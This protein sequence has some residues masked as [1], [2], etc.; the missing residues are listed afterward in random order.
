VFDACQSGAVT[1]FKGGKRAEPFYLKSQRQI[2]G[3]V[4]IA[5][6]SSNELAQESETLKGSIFSHHWF[7]G[8]RGSAD[9]SGDGEVTVS[10]AYQYAYRKTIETTALSGG[11]VQHPQYRF[12]I[13][14]HGDIALTSLG[15]GSAG[16]VFDK[17]FQGKF[18]VLSDT[19]SD[20]YADFARK[21]GQET[22]IA[23]PPGTYTVVNVTDKET[24][25][26]DFNLDQSTVYRIQQESLLPNPV[27]MNRVKGANLAASKSL[28]MTTGPLSTYSWGLGAGAVIA[29][30]P[31]L[32][33]ERAI[34]KVGWANSLY[35]SDNT[36]LFFNADWIAFGRNFSGDIGFDYTWPGAFFHPFAGIGVGVAN[37]DKGASAM[38][39][40]LGPSATV[41]LGFN[42]EI[43]GRTGLR[44]QV[45]YT[46]V[47]NDATDQ[48][49]GL[50]VQLMW[51]GKFRDVRVLHVF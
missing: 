17:T 45:P 37:F 40:T 12:N 23:L 36:S 2:E 35:I 34:L 29:L 30:S 11:Q 38:R 27:A 13:H 32:R 10:E 22:F 4:I 39:E 44:I 31:E 50:E 28:E 21:S 8:L 42:R 25:V 49:I 16:I 14:G 26:H 43:G 47:F 7:N 48:T 18:L 9:V 15:H 20:V 3:E 51:F 41:H 5:S 6:S 1:R 33:E 46:V 19:Y 24:R